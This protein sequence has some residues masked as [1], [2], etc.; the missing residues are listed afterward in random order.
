[1]RLLENS[2]FT[3]E[4]L[5]ILRPYIPGVL[6]WLAVA[7]LSLLSVYYVADNF[8]SP[9][10]DRMADIAFVSSVI[11]GLLA[12]WWKGIRSGRWHPLEKIKAHPV[13]AGLLA[14]TADEGGWWPNFADNEAALDMLL[15]SIEAAGLGTE[16]SFSGGFVIG[17]ETGTARR[18]YGPYPSVATG[19]IRTVAAARSVVMFE[20]TIALKARSW[21]ASNAWDADFPRVCSS[22]MRS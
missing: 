17:S 15:R 20:S 14:G 10:T 22:R 1:M 16:A 4:E 18:I 19:P 21:P 13:E 12:V 5:E 8:K 9:E 7:G 2:P 11:L 6:L 3:A